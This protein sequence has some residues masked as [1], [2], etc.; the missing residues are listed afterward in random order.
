MKFTEEKLEK[1]DL[2]LN[3]QLSMINRMEKLH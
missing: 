3:A 2:M 1:A